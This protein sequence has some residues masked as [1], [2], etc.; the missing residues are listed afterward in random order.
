M[1]ILASALLSFLM[2]RAV[3][4]LSQGYHRAKEF[5]LAAQRGRRSYDPPPLTGL[6]L[7]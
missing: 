1:K 4:M 7:A 5:D 3:M 6:C 2:Q